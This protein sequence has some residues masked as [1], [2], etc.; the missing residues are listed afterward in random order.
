MN[1]DLEL[2]VGVVI[3]CF[4]E[5]SFI[6]GVLEKI[7]EFVSKVYVIDD[8]CPEGT[9]DHVESNINQERVIVLRHKT[10][11]GVGGAVLTGYSHAI[12]DGIKIIVK[13]DGDGQ[14]NPAHITRFVDPIVSGDADYTKG[15]RFYQLRALKQMPKNRLIGNML[16]TFLSKASSGYW[17]IFD[18]TNGYTA[19]HSAIL[20]RLYLG[21]ISTDFFFESDMLCKL[22][23]VRARVQDI[24]MDARYGNEKS[25]LVVHKII[26]PFFY[27]HSKRLVERLLH[28]YFFRDFS[29]ASIA[30]VLGLFLSGFGIIFG[31]YQ[32]HSHFLRS[33]LASVGTVMLA[34][35]PLI[36]GMQFLFSFINYDIANV[37]QQAVHPKITNDVIDSFKN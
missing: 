36:L 2:K 10:N 29:T 24:P 7:P 19:I 1:P 9:G 6:C 31:L 16:L 30:L 33:E 11:R 22:G 35:L 32:W 12:Q 8:A 13:L 34:A 27:R 37:P 3:P 14:M 21:R 15:N 17:N 23:E 26:A 20:N 28:N 25:S 4:R 18:P 5:K